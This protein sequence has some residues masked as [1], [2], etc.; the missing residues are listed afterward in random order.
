MYSYNFIIMRTHK[1]ACTLMHAR[2]ITIIHTHA[3]AN[4]CTYM[5]AYVKTMHPHKRTYIECTHKHQCMYNYNLSVLCRHLH[6]RH[7]HW[8]RPYHARSVIYNINVSLENNFVIHN[9]FRQPQTSYSTA[10][11]ATTVQ[12]PSY[13]TSTSTIYTSAIHDMQDYT[14]Y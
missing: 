2:I 9:R 7:P 14:L 4:A 11:T 8:Q 12:S 5:H 1:H 6:P 3:K 13:L 10:L